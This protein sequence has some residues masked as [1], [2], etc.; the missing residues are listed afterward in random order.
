MAVATL[1]QL[2]LLGATLTSISRFTQSGHRIP[3]YGHFVNDLSPKMPTHL[4]KITIPIVSS[5]VCY[6]RT[7]RP[8]S[9]VYFELALFMSHGLRALSVCMPVPLVLPCVL[10]SYPTHAPPTRLVGPCTYLDIPLQR[11]F[12]LPTRRTSLSFGYLLLSSPFHL[13]CRWQAVLLS[14][15]DVCSP[16]IFVVLLALFVL[17]A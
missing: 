13:V 9:T 3:D 5:S 7:S 4:P 1:T 11:E 6:R 10:H 12:L 14:T 17:R 15:H 16:H 2:I 8:T